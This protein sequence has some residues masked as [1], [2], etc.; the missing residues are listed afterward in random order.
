MD[1]G[2]ETKFNLDLI[3]GQNEI[4]NSYGRVLSLDKL[5]IMPCLNEVKAPGSF[6][7]ENSSTRLQKCGR[8]S[9]QGESPFENCGRNNFKGQW[10]FLSK[11]INSDQPDFT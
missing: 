6:D 3:P 11:L 2:G 8:N 10:Q 5:Y 4:D 7:K 1:I 9:F